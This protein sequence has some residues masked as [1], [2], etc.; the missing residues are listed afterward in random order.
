[1]NFTPMTRYIVKCTVKITLFLCLI[2]VQGSYRIPH[3]KIYFL[4]TILESEMIRDLEFLHGL[5]GP[6]FLLK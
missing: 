2:V 1:M 4:I 6:P 5:K 3:G